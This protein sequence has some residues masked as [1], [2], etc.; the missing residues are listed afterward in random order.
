MNRFY[1]ILRNIFVRASSF[2]S[3]VYTSALQ[4]YRKQGRVL[5]S[6]EVQWLSARICPVKRD[7]SGWFINPPLP[8]W[9]IRPDERTLEREEF[10]LVRYWKALDLREATTS[11]GSSNYAKPEPGGLPG[12]GF[13]RAE[14]VKGRHA[15]EL[16][17]RHLIED[18][19]VIRPICEQFGSMSFCLDSARLLHKAN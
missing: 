3:D 15:N 8:G 7:G 18:G 13:A 5:R 4:G 19:N 11:M 9:Q 6:T 2:I 14:R 17:K 10:G 1:H 12:G 16:G